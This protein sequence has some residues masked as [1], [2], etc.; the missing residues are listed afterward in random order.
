MSKSKDIIEID[1]LMI[2]E[3]RPFNH[4]DKSVIG[5]CVAD[6]AVNTDISELP[7]DEFI[8]AGIYII[9]Y[10]GN[11]PLYKKIADNNKDGQ[12]NAPIYIGKAVPS[13][14]RKGR[15]GESDNP[16][17]VL[18]KRLKDHEKSISSAKNIQLKDFKC[19]FLTVDDIWIPLAESLLISR[20]SPVWNLIVEGFGNHDPGK[21]RI[22]GK[23][24]LWD[25]LH[26]GREWAN[27]LKDPAISLAELKKKV[28]D[29][30]DEQFPDD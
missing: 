19:K 23:K 27:N 1:E 15:F 20:Y 6:A 3:Y 30:L 26:P 13:G 18:Y 8:G 2:D 5:K 10:T 11:F 24:P 25:L 12:Y 17:N 9:Y 16:G 21:G 28:T 14:S 22:E 7:P 29:F 4:L